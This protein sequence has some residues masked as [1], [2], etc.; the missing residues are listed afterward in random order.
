MAEKATSSAMVDIATGEIVESTNGLTFTNV[1]VPEEFQEIVS[2]VERPIVAWA[3]SR[4]AEE[5]PNSDINPVFGTLIGAKYVDN[6]QGEYLMLILDSP[7]TTELRAIHC[8]HK[9]LADEF[10]KRIERNHLLP[11]DQVSIKYI[12]L[13]TAKPKQSPPKIYRVEV[14]HPGRPFLPIEVEARP[15][16]ERTFDT[17]AQLLPS[18]S[19]LEQSS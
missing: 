7:Q 5:S 10:G 11:G 1:P 14:R 19:A 15:T 4:D 17:T 6:E 3:Y 9:V 13:G 18:A 16:S 12:G 2:W 8:F